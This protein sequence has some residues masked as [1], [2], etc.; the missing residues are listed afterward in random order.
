MIYVSSYRRLGQYD[1]D[2]LIGA[3]E[4][5]EKAMEAV[6]VYHK[7][8]DDPPDHHAPVLEDFVALRRSNRPGD[9]AKWQAYA[10]EDRGGSFYTITELPIQ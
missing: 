10:G 5:L 1:G 4:T 3:F 8:T 6:Q 9:V 7:A 2:G